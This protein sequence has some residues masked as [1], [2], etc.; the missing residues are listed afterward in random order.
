MTK[1]CFYSS[2]ANKTHS[3]GDILQGLHDKL[4]DVDEKGC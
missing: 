3:A 1:T 2:L 4:L